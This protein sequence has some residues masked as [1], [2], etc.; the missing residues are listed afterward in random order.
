[1]Q[2][3]KASLEQQLAAAYQEA[4]LTAETL[5]LLRQ[6]RDH[7]LAAQAEE[8]AALQAELAAA[9]Y[10]QDGQLC[11]LAADLGAV[12]GQLGALQRERGGLA[13]AGGKL[14]GE[15]EGQARELAAL[16]QQLDGVHA[17]QAEPEAAQ[18]SGHGL[19]CLRTTLLFFFL[20]ARGGLCW[21]AACLP[22]SEGCV[23]LT[24]RLT[25]GCP[26]RWPPCRRSWMARVL[27]WQSCAP[28][29]RS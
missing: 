18:V 22:R 29:S 16:R 15:R 26:V 17:L 8:V 10:E 21:W 11:Q 2:A 25:P 19:A 12:R 20:R 7:T 28:A 9:R 4:R 14:A 3:H 27:S 1:M 13:K 5:G 24:G 23:G 6:D